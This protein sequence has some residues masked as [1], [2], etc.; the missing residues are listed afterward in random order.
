[1]KALP[2]LQP[3]LTVDDVAKLLRISR[4]SVYNLVK[5]GDLKPVRIGSLRK[6]R[7]R[8]RDVQELL[9]P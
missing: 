8:R 6:T 5:T 1:M 4:A 7:F 3:L 2:E 9:T